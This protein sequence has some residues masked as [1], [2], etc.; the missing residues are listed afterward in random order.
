M[1]GDVVLALV[2]YSIVAKTPSSCLFL[3]LAISVSAQKRRRDLFIGE[4]NGKIEVLYLLR[5]LTHNHAFM[6]L[7]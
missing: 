6:T 4:R 2:L 1:K 7:G 3:L 5:V